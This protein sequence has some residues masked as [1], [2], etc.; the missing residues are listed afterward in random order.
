MLATP[1]VASAVRS[2]P[3]SGRVALIASCGPGAPGAKRG[4]SRLRYSP[5]SSLLRGFPVGIAMIIPSILRIRYT[6]IDD[7]LDGI[8]LR[9]VS[10]TISRIRNTRMPDQISLRFWCVPTRKSEPSTSEPNTAMRVSAIRF[11]T[12]LWQVLETEA[13]RVGVSVSQYVREAALTRAAAAAAARGEDPF[14]LLAVPAPGVAP[15]PLARLRVPAP[16]SGHD[17]GAA[18]SGARA[19]TAGSRDTLDAARAALERAQAAFDAAVA[20]SAESEQT[21][22]HSRRTKSTSHGFA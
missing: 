1:G 9:A 11:G 21:R 7:S 17:A 2:A 20:V 12:D 5:G 4:V 15:A 6:L 18:V 19:H 16:A 8:R 10:S 22:R 14:Q 13:A 3:G